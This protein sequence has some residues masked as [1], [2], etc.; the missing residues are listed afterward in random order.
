MSLV[1]RRF[2]ALLSGCGLLASIGFYTGSYRG[3]NFDSVM[4]WPF[5]LH[6]GAIVLTLPMFAVEGVAV[7]NRTF[8]WNEFARGKPSW[9]VPSI[10]ILGLLFALQ[11]ILFLVQ[12]HMASPQIK[13]G[14]YVLENHRKVIAVLSQLEYFRLKSGELRMFAVGWVF[15]YFVPTMYWWFPGDRQG[16]ASATRLAG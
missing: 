8:F 16:S 6:L 5:V 9:V 12:S 15:F 14:Q 1:I 7:R 3:I 10:R 4:P 11:F 13:D 2:L